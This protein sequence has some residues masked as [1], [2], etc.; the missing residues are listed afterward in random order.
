MSPSRW[1]MPPVYL[2]SGNPENEDNATLAYKGQLGVRFTVTNP[3]RSPADNTTGAGRSKGYQVVKTDST[4]SVS[5]FPGAVAWWADKTQY[6]VTTSVTKLG[7]GRVAGV[8]RN[9]PTKGNFT[10]IQVEGPA[11]VKIVDSPASPAVANTGQ[12]VIP[13]ATDGKADLLAAGTAASY[14]ALGVVAGALNLGD[15]TIIVDLDVP[16]ST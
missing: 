11:P 16:V 12:F 9:S 3:Q 1:D 6:M 5:P 7:R 15:N 13:S 10:C 2:Q 14:P 8:F 4:M